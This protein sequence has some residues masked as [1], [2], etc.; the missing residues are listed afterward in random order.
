MKE[1][2]LRLF[3]RY[4]IKLLSLLVLLGQGIGFGARGLGRVL[5]GALRHLLPVLLFF[6]FRGRKIKLRL[7]QFIAPLKGH[8]LYLFGH[9][10]FVHSLVIALVF[11][12]SLPALRAADATAGNFGEQ[13][14]LRELVSS[15]EEEQQ[16]VDDTLPTSDEFASYLEGVFQNQPPLISESELPLSLDGDT[17]MKQEIPG[18]E[19]PITRTEIVEYEVQ[20]GDTPWAIAEEFGLTVSTVLWENKMT[21]YSTIRPGQKLTILP[22]SGV[23]HTVKKGETLEGIAKKYGASLE[24]VQQVNKLAAVTLASGVKL[25]IPGGRP[26]FAPPIAQPARREIVVPPSVAVIPGGKLLWP[27]ISKRITQY[28]KWRHAGLDVG[29]KAGSPIYASENGVVESAGWGRGG[30]GNTVVVDHGNGMK[31]RYSHASKVLVAAG[32][33]VSKGQTIALVGSTGRSTGPHLD[34]RI[35]LNGRTVNP[36]QYLR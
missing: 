29:D 6:Y 8:T 28:F 23:T 11:L 34:F 21:L 5:A 35:Y 9:R 33:P 20:P 18:T 25:V 15:P 30:W 7:A 22:V 17:L 27:V 2:F 16:V 3:I 31:T 13:L 1:S 26:Y 10:Y 36:L 32:Q 12:S 4:G 19:M 24:E 14:L